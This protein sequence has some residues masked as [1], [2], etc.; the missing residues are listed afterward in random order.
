MNR[1]KFQSFP[2]CARYYLA[3]AGAGAAGGDWRVPGGE[4]LEFA[5]TAGLAAA[6][7]V[8]AAGLIQQA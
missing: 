2:G 6:A 7:W 3:G 5:G 8:C 4:A 1:E